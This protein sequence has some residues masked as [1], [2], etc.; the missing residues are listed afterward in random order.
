V[1]KILHRFIL[2]LVRS[3]KQRRFEGWKMDG[4]TIVTDPGNRSKSLKF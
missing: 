3:K 1:R 2:N 4:D